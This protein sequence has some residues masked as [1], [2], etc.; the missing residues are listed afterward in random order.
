MSGDTACSSKKKYE[1]GISPA[2]EEIIPSS[3]G[4]VAWRRGDG[5]S[6]ASLITRPGVGDVSAGRGRCSQHPQHHVSR[7]VA[8]HEGGPAFTPTQRPP[9]CRL[10]GGGRAGPRGGG[11]GAGQ[12]QQKVQSGHQPAGEES[13]PSSYGR[14]AWRRGTSPLRSSNGGRA[15]LS[16]GRVRPKLRCNAAAYSMP[17]LFTARIMQPRAGSCDTRANFSSLS[18]FSRCSYSS[19]R[20]HRLFLSRVYTLCSIWDPAST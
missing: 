18:C 15:S 9:T 17:P 3:Y 14:V 5:K 10:G 1:A 2:G 4:R 19:R 13:I 11:G 7:G 8:D 16:P 12:Q 20:S 6:P